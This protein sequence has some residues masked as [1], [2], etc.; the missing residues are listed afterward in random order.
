[1]LHTRRHTYHHIIDN[2]TAQQGAWQCY[3]CYLLNFGSASKCQACSLSKFRTKFD[4]SKGYAHLS[5]NDLAAIIL[6]CDATELQEIASSLAYKSAVYRKH[7]FLSL[8][9]DIGKINLI[10]LLFDEGFPF[11]LNYREAHHH[12]RRSTNATKCKAS[13]YT[14]HRV[15]RPN[16]Q[17]RNHSQSYVAP[18]EILPLSMAFE[19]DEL[20][21]IK[22]LLQKGASP[23]QCT[24]ASALAL[25]YEWFDLSRYEVLLHHLPIS[26]PI[27][28]SRRRRRQ[29][30]RNQNQTHSVVELGEYEEIF[31]LLI[32]RGAQ[33]V[34]DEFMALFCNND[35]AE[36]MAFLTEY[37]N[38]RE[39]FLM[40]SAMK[41]HYARRVRPRILKGSLCVVEPI[42]A[43]YLTTFPMMDIDEEEDGDNSEDDEKKDESD[44][45]A[46]SEEEEMD[47]IVGKYKQ[48]KRRGRNQRSRMYVKIEAKI[49]S[50]QRP[51]EREYLVAT[52]SGMQMKLI[53]HDERVWREL[54][55]GDVI[56]VDDAKRIGEE[57]KE[58][59]SISSSSSSSTKGMFTITHSMTL[60]PSVC[61][62]VK[63]EV[64][65]R[66]EPKMKKK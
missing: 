52:A 14:A 38:R 31:D 47:D 10:F 27:I 11:A 50:E 17:S 51:F 49:S 5:D 24:N 3:S 64:K 57:K 65:D 39:R 59:D 42:I 15:H 22:L 23:N 63:A 33:W 43:Q 30:H 12:S 34:E 28:K 8:L 55:V 62:V 66:F 46:K 18:D 53:V 54:K 37:S 6:K 56:S 58:T 45:D 25:H 36:W 29:R 40:H 7:S 41:K 61:V 19:R 20:Y 35:A 9:I 13:A 4:L 48:H 32:E 60:T 16:Q 26:V 21:L 44:D 1:M 2:T